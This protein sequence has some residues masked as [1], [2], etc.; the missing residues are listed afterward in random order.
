MA[1]CLQRVHGGGEPWLRSSGTLSALQKLHDKGHIGDA[2]F[3]ELGETYGLLRAIEHRLQCRQ[4]GQS[5]RLPREAS[6]Q[7]ALFRSL[8]DGA[9]RSAQELKR[10]MKSASDLC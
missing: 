8:G 2:E 5:H 4:G 3:R 1:Q 9:I 7:V 10:I 6:E